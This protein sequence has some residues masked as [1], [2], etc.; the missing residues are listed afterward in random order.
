M[1]SSTEGSCSCSFW[2]YHYTAFVV[3]KNMLLLYNLVLCEKVHTLFYNDWNKVY[4]KVNVF[5]WDGNR[6]PG[7]NLP[8]EP[9][10]KKPSCLPVPGFELWSPGWGWHS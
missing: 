7:E 9:R 3:N 8:V 1:V 4:R 2:S 5:L 6:L 10:D